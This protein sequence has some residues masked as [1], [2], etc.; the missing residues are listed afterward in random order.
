MHDQQRHQQNKKNRQAGQSRQHPGDDQQRT[1]DF[2][3]D[4]QDQREVGTE[5]ERVFDELQLRGEVQQLGQ[6]VDEQ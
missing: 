3:E 1:E 4:R 5:M 6:A 2:G